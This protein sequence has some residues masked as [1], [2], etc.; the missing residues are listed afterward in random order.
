VK[1]EKKKRGSDTHHSCMEG[2]IAESTEKSTF[3]GGSLL[4]MVTDGP[5]HG[6]NPR[7]HLLVK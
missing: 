4:L 3:T 1:E 7:P 6:V 5:I 2:W